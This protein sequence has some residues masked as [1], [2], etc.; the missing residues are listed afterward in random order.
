MQDTAQYDEIE[1][2]KNGTPVRI[3]AIGAHD[4]DRLAEAFHNLEAESIYTRFFHHKKMLT[5]AELKTATEIDFDK[6]VALVATVGEGDEEVIIGG[7]RYVSFGDARPLP[8]AEVAFTIEED[9]QGQ[10]LA[11]RLL[12]HLIAI[13]REKGLARFEAEVLAENKAMLTVFERSGLPVTKAYEGG[14]LHVT[15]SLAGTGA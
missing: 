2:L 10:G 1:T 5:E 8:S 15:L 6:V 9:Y 13:G 12:R 3:R 4:K 7:G 11:S 14:T